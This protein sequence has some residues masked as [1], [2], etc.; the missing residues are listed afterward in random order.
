MAGVVIA[1]AILFSLFRALTPW[2]KQYKHEVEHHLSTILGTPVT[3][4]N[5]ETSWYWFAPV[6]KLDDINILAEKNNSIQLK[7]LLVGIDLFRSLLTWQIQPGILYID[8]LK[9]TVKENGN[10]WQVVGFTQ[11]GNSVKVDSS[12]YLPLVSWLLNQQKIVIKNISV[13]LN[14]DDSTVLPIEQLNLA[15]SNNFGHYKIHGSGKLAQKISTEILLAADL[16]TNANFTENLNGNIYLKVNNFLPAQWQSIFKNKNF[17]IKNGRGD[18]EFWLQMEKGKLHTIQSNVKLQNLALAVGNKFNSI[19]DFSANLLWNKTQEGWKFQGDHVNIQTKGLNWKEHTFNLEYQQEAEM[20]RFFLNKFQIQSLFSLN[21][22]LPE[23]LSSI[24]KYNL[25]GELN[26]LQVGIKKGSLNYCLSHFK[27]LSWSKS[28]YYPGI[29]NLSGILYWEPNEGRLELDSK[30]TT[31]IP[32]NRKPVNISQI[33]AAFDWKLLSQG[34]RANIDRLVIIRPD[35]VLNAQGLVDEINSEPHINLNG[36]F[37]ASDA[38]KWLEYIPSTKKPKLDSWI[39]NNIK[40]VD[41]L[42]GQFKV[43]GKLK[44]FPY[45]NGEGEFS[46]TTHLQG[47]DLIFRKNWPLSKNIDGY[48]RLRGRNLAVDVLNADLQ[49]VPVN[50]VN[51]KINEIGFDKETLL[52]HGKLVADAE[53]IKNFILESPLKS[54][55]KQLESTHLFGPLALDLRVEVPLY[56]NDDEIHALGRIDLNNNEVT[57]KNTQGE[58][59]NIYGFLTFDEFGILNGEVNTKLWNDP[60]EL[61]FQAQRFNNHHNLEIIATGSSTIDLL[62]NKFNLTLPFIN[63]NFN[64]L[65]TINFSDSDKIHINF[66]TSLFGL[67]LDVPEPFGKSSNEVIPLNVDMDFTNNALSKLRFDYDTK[68]VGVID[69]TK[70]KP[71]GVINLGKN[72]QKNDLSL[73]NDK[74]NLTGYLEK[75]DVNNWYNI[76]QKIPQGNSHINLIDSMKLHNLKIGTLIIFDQ[77]FNNLNVNGSKL[78]NQSLALKVQHKDLI[79]DLNYLQSTHHLKAHLNHLRIEKELLTAATINEKHDLHL[80][81]NEMPNLNLTI[82]N[83]ELGELNLGRL[84]VEAH[85]SNNNW[86]LK[87]LELKSPFYDLVL[88]GNWDKEQN[89]TNI[90]AK[91]QMKDLSETLQKLNITTAVEAD[92]SITYLEVKWPGAIYDFSIPKI[93]GRIHTIVRNGRISNFSPETE[94]KLGFAKLLS[95]LSL[96][97]IPRR[98]K[99]DFSDWSKTGYSFDV[100]K[101]NFIINHGIMNTKDSYI[102]GPVA[103]ASIKGDIN[104]AKQSYDLNLHVAP[105][106]TASLPVVATIAGGP[107]AGI[108]TWV[109]SKIVNQGME[110]ISG[111]TYKISGPW[112]DPLVQQVTI[113]KSPSTKYPQHKPRFWKTKN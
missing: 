63:G 87:E 13:T 36:E 92:T 48:L 67:A 41:K 56:S 17:K 25:A 10:N 102:D 77:T 65:G 4:K 27:N 72:L 54:K 66:K 96:Q 14:L 46:L 28:T 40:K 112:T 113:I 29:K 23:D 100:Y 89:A 49:E 91:L 69:F 26:N 70:N 37:S 2:A 62:K 106:I 15:I 99:L 103:Y 105:H 16:Q 79:A 8:D 50:K 94:E 58:F 108:A 18:G 53:K 22:D 32:N 107:I 59:K 3:V 31:I 93:N 34:Y 82:D 84:T 21:I 33:N 55:L 97:T 44:D 60:L 52:C 75:L 71:H 5:M 64:V 90:S 51:I 9:L 6:L 85:R 86:L 43:F 74:L 111:Y 78:N 76:L 38:Q 35:V 39:Q 104:L 47:V 101:G 20:Y 110:K 24:L 57:E 68:A 42:A 30:N 7:K 83:F 88:N 81:P 45:D 109:I 80:K 1:L 95:I 12:S 61:H 73:N 11:S 98:L 19:N